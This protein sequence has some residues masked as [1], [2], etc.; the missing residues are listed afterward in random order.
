MTSSASNGS[1]TR[2]PSSEIMQKPKRQRFSTEE[3]L[4]ILREADDWERG[5]SVHCCAA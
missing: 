2:L 3:K 1:A 5:R 4:R